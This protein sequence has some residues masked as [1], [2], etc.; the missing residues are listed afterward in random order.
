MQAPE[1][2]TQAAIRNSGPRIDE[3][4]WRPL[5]N[6]PDIKHRAPNPKR[7][8]KVGSFDKQ[9]I[10]ALKCLLP[11]LL[12]RLFRHWTLMIND[13]LLYDVRPAAKLQSCGQALKHWA[14]LEK[15]AGD[16]GGIEESHGATTP[17]DVSGAAPLCAFFKR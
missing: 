9:H 13:L 2:F 14:R 11:L 15:S 8:G 10:E 17:P 4:G 12:A 7:S 3:T 6:Y 5:Q 16:T 1:T